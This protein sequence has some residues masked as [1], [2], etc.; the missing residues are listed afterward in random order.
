MTELRSVDRGFRLWDVANCEAHVR[1]TLDATLKAAGA[2]LNGAQYERAFA[3]LLAKCWELSGL[4]GD[5]KTLRHVYEVHGFLVPRRLGEEFQPIKLPQF[6]RR[7][8][9]EAILEELQRRRRVSFLKID[10][11]RPR[12]AYDASFG[13][14][15]STYSR[16]ILSQRVWDWYRSDPEFGDTRYESRREHEESLE[17][18]AGRRRDDQDPD[19]SFL[20]RHGPGARLDHIDELNPPAYR[21]EFEEVLTIAAIGR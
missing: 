19:G 15:F 14:S 2:R 11:V 9:A 7:E 3:F 6:P 18:L 20:D 16:R 10:R 4:E 13:I 12:G 5:G 17:A 8:T 21:I 1:A